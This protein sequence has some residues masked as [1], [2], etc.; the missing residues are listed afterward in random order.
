[1]YDVITIGSATKDAFLVSKE[2]KI[3]PDPKSP[4]GKLECIPFGSKIELDEMVL[5]TG[6]GATNAAA[7]F[8]SLGFKTACITRIGDD[9]D[10]KAVLADLKKFKVKTPLV[11]VVKGGQTG[12]GALLTASN[13]ERSVLVHRGVAGEFTDRSVALSKLKTKWI[14]MSSL[15]GNT[16]L[17]LRIVKY[18]SKKGIKVAYNPGSKEL[19]KGLA[20]FGPIMRHLTILNINLEEA[21]MLANSKSRDVKVLAKKILH[22]GMHLLITDGPRGSYLATDEGIVFARTRNVKVISRTGAGDAF[23]AGTVSAIMKGSSVE[24]ALKVGT[25]NAESVIQSYGAKFGILTAWPRES[26]LKQIK[27]RKLD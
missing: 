24:E 2:F 15:A 17:A 26:V 7:T 11:K 8:G 19:K 23:G 6:G 16:A 13:G 12:F 21:M 25:I 14:Y 18:A 20:T 3:L 5:T 4:T 9:D 22:P 10:G 27:V 1:M